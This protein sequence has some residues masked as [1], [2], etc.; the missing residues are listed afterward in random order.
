[1]RKTLLYQEYAELEPARMEYHGWEIAARFRSV[2]EEYEALHHGAGLIDLSHRGRLLVRGEDAPRFLHGMV[3]NEV[4]ELAAGHGNYA[5]V[6]DPK[7][8]ILADARVLRLDAES[9]L[10]DCEPH[11]LEVIRKQLDDHIIADAVELE[12]QSAQLA[13]LAVEGPKAAEAIRHAAGMEVSQ[14]DAFEHV[15]FED[16]SLRLVRASASG[17]VGYLI[18][19]A[20]E[21]AAEFW[22]KAMGLATEAQRTQRKSMEPS[23]QDSLGES[24]A[25]TR[26]VGF[27]ALEIRRIERGTPRYGMD[28]DAKTLP[29]ETGQMHAISFTK[30]CYIGQETVERIHSRGHVNR[31][32][33]GLRFRERCEMAR[34]MM[35]LVKGHPSGFTTSVAYSPGLGR[36]I[37]L[38]YLRRDMSEPGTPVQV[39]NQDGEVAELPFGSDLSKH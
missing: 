12:D 3:T 33:V 11:L 24:E 32:L 23:P 17:A 16:A 39:N 15:Y 4:K 19:A 13:C 38:A 7:G 31:L 28:M 36:T 8:H 27:E 9:Y 14:M 29:Q 22:R 1:M 6:L 37:A 34:D 5:F 10:V 26:P 18:L 21:K 2:E 20:P 25:G 30:G 35:V